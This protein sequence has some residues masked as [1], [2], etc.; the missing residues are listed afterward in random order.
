VL[1]HLGT[2]RFFSDPISVHVLCL[3]HFL[4]KASSSKYGHLVL[5]K[6]SLRTQQFLSKTSN[7]PTS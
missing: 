2:Y 6:S 4:R 7:Q 1:V 5:S 3:W